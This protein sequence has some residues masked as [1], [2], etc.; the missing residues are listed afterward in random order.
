MKLFS[1]FQNE[2]GKKKTLSN[3]FVLSTLQDF[4]AI[5]IMIISNSK[6]YI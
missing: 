1:N 3:Y 4:Y 6:I 5:S 2:L